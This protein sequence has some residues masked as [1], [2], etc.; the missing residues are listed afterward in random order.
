MNSC[1][2]CDNDLDKHKSRRDEKYYDDNDLCEYI[3]CW[4]C[5]ALIEYKVNGKIEWDIKDRINETLN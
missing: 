3:Y 5:D 4:Y 1:L 2:M